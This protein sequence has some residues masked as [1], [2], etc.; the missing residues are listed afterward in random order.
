MD[1]LKTL[2]NSLLLFVFNKKAAEEISKVD[3]KEPFLL[4]LIISIL[5]TVLSTLVELFINP[6]LGLFSLLT[7][8]GSIIFT[9]TF[10]VA[11]FFIFGGYIHLFY[12]L[13]KGKGKYLDTL[14]GYGAVASGSTIVFTLISLILVFLVTIFGLMLFGGNFDNFVPNIFLFVVIGFFVLVMIIYMW[15]VYA[16]AFTKIHQIGFGKSFVVIFV[17]MLIMFLIIAIIFAIFFFIFLA[18]YGVGSALF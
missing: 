8:V 2:K 16:F 3:W 12:K 11:M 18:L 15:A 6:I 1:L 7:M 14:K 5:M 17:A 13:F 9:L 4:F 10:G